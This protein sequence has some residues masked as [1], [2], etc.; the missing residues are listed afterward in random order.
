MIIEV[1]ASLFVRIDQSLILVSDEYL[2]PQLQCLNCG[3]K[4]GE[5]GIKV[6]AAESSTNGYKT[7]QTKVYF[8]FCV[9][10]VASERFC[11]LP[12]FTHTM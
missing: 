5:F 9:A 3:H 12:N 2:L 10:S 7:F 4:E 6:S 8:E 1:C 11:D